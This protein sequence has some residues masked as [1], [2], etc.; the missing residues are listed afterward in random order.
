MID[1][2]VRGRTLSRP[3]SLAASLTRFYADRGN[4]RALITAALLLCYGGGV[5]MFEVHYNIRR[6]CGPPINAVWHWL[7]DST[8]GFLALSPLLA[9]LLPAASIALDRV[10]PG[11]ATPSGVLPRALLIGSAF[12]LATTPGPYVHDLL[13]SQGR[14]LARLATAV[15]GQDAAAMAHNA[16]GLEHSMLSE[17]LIQ[18][19]VG[20][21]VYIV[22]TALAL[23][24]TRA[25]LNVDRRG[26]TGPA[27]PQAAPLAPK[28]H[29]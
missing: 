23:T 26:A 17:G 4:R 27:A 15:F 14:P 25:A 11:R 5:V 9:V 6:E 3:G 18:L 29:V 19:A 13:A 1:N 24:V 28:V 21:P 22:L 12:A 2:A 10:R 8:I 16:H 7:L 20:L